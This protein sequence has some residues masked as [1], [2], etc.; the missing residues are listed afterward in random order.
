MS[1]LDNHFTDV[2]I[3]AAG[4][5]SQD[6]YLNAIDPDDL[7]ATLS[8]YE[9]VMDWTD[10][11]DAFDETHLKLWEQVRDSEELHRLVV[12]GHALYDQ[13]FQPGTD[14]RQ[15]VNRLPPGALLDI[16]WVESGAQVPDVPWTLMYALDPA[17]E[18]DPLGFLGL[19][20]R[21]KYAA[22]PS[23]SGRNTWIDNP[24]ACCLFWGR[25]AAEADTAA[26]ADRHYS[27]TGSVPRLFVPAAGHAG[28][29]KPALI[30]LL[31]GA[32]DD[33]TAVGIL[34]MFCHYG[35]LPGNDWG[36]IFGDTNDEPDVLSLFDLQE[37]TLRSAP[38]VIANACKTG[39]SDALHAHPIKQYFF[40]HGAA[41]YL[42]TETEVPIHLASRFAT[43]FVH[44]FD[45]APGGLTLVAGE[46]VTQARLLLWT[47]YRNIGGLLYSLVNQYDVRW[48]TQTEL[49]QAR[50]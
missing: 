48:R 49:S 10:L 42:G 3:A 39:A 29:A 27:W 43:T 21:L 30:G 7:A 14:L 25:S 20:Y 26:E 28:P 4:L 16:T 1:S 9:P 44:M 31:Q 38:L 36:F 12:R 34:Y 47:R 11:Q 23:R 19:R 8:S 5:L 41:A 13:I 45:D 33:Q 32:D 15:A 22:Y 37:I 40:T 24:E 18:V 17:A 35:S 2:R 6:E 46:A 50:A